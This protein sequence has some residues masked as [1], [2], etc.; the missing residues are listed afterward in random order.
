MTLFD[1][2]HCAWLLGYSLLW[3][4][5]YHL[6]A[7]STHLGRDLG[8]IRYLGRP[9]WLSNC[10]YPKGQTKSKQNCCK[11]KYIKNKL[12]TLMRP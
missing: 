7:L 5:R 11:N 10:Y 9:Q 12:L 2:A 1:L 8:V 6:A 3:H 4:F